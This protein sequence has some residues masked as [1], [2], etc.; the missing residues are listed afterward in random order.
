[1]NLNVMCNLNDRSIGLL[2][3][4]YCVSLAK[5]GVDISLFNIHPPQPNLHLSEEEAR[6]LNGQINK[7][8]SFDPEATS[9]R[10]WHG[11]DLAP[12][13][14]RGKRVC[15]SSFELDPILPHEVHHLNS[16]DLAFFPNKWAVGVAERSGIKT[17]CDSFPHGVNRSVF[18]EFGRLP[19]TEGEPTRFLS[20]GKFEVRKFHEG[21]PALFDAAFTEDDNVELYISHFNPFSTE[22]ETKKWL[23]LYSNSK[24]AKKI[25]L[26]NWVNNPADLAQLMRNC[27]CMI[28]LSKGEAF[29][30]PLLEGL[31]T[32]IHVI[33][34]NYSGHTEFL[35]Q[36]NARL[37]EINSLEPAFDGKWFHGQSNW[38]FIGKNQIEQA[39]AHMRDVHKLCQEGNLDINSKGIEKAE[40]L[41][42]IKATNV[43]VDKLSDRGLL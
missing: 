23:D 13:I 15:Y 10:I 43:L 21:L 6:I 11:H 32:G 14:G 18:N 3:V 25:R 39:V 38:A 27:D 12:S 16:M 19:K 40:E 36:D 1:M 20:V 7:A 28:S 9:L 34:T 33:A 4:N 29:N 17:E 26:V 41:T 35:N 5:L 2:G 24:L 30:M 42:W 22:D 37:V 8:H 31:S